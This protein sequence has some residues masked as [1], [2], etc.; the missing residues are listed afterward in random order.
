M[1]KYVKNISAILIYIFFDTIFYLITKLI[2]I[3]YNSFN[4]LKKTIYLIING[5]FMIFI[6]IFIYKDEL[7]KDFNDY[8]KN[9]K[10]YFDKYFKVYVFGV[11]LMGI[12]NTIIS[13]FTHMEISENEEIIRNL[14]DTMPIYITF[15]TV[16]YAPLIEEL[17]YRKCIRN[18]ISND[19]AFIY[20]SGLI[21]GLMHVISGHETINDILMSIPYIIIGID[22]AFIYYKTKN[23]FSTIQ[24][25]F[26]HNL[27]LLIIQFI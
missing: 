5:L 16:L 8:K 11:L 6:L 24:F 14:V 9:F 22:F 26:L 21:F 3:D 10:F 25:H 18:L 12:S 13:K 23:I 1:K 7:K 19:I 17:I 2:N 20:M 27:L 15:S 4:S